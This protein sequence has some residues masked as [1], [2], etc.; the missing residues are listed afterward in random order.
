[1]YRQFNQLALVEYQL[2][3]EVVPED[4]IPENFTEL[5]MKPPKFKK[6]RDRDGK[7]L[8]IKASIF[9]C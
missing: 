9:N 1:M 4:D 5:K 3:A 8:S 6:V 7:D 2:I